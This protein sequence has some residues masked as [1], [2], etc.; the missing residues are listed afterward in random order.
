MT[1][2]LVYVHLPH[3]PE[4][5]DLACRFVATYHEYPPQIPHETIVVCNGTAPTHHTRV[6]FGSLPHVRF[7]DHDDSGWDVG[8]FIAASHQTE[9]EMMFCCGG[10]CYFKRAGWLKRIA[11][12]WERYGPGMYGTLASYEIRP[13]FCTSGFAVAPDMLRNHPKVSTKEER[14]AFEHGENSLVLRTLR[15]GKPAMLVTWDG[16][17]HW[18]Q[19][20]T[21]PNIYC[22]GDQ[23]NCLTFFRH[24]DS[25]AQSDFGEQRRRQHLADTYVNCPSLPKCDWTQRSNVPTTGTLS[26]VVTQV[27]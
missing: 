16:A 9:A 23:S 27:R 22:K 3:D 20:R 13:H 5:V 10:P 15:Q 24:S 18:P 8:A 21:P 4:H 7:M 14:Y 6:L 12:A 1:I 2:S 11:E 17:W 26:S 19:W 25:Y